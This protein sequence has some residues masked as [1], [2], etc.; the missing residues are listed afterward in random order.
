MTHRSLSM[1]QISLRPI[2]L[3]ACLPLLW[4]LLTPGVRADVFG[5]LRISVRDAAGKPVQSANIIFHD[6]AGV[7]TDF[8]VLSDASGSVLSPPLEN[9]PWRITTQIVTFNTDTR[10]V[11]VAAD[12]T[13]EVA[14]LLTKR[15]VSRTSTVTLGRSP[16][17]DSTRLGQSDIR[18]IPLTG[19]NPQNFSRTLLR[20]PGFVGSSVNVVHPR[21]E[22]GSLSIY[23]D[24]FQL[25]GALQGR[26]GPLISPD[27]I[28]SA[29]IQTG[30]YAPEYGSETAAVVNLSLRSG[31]IKPFGSVSFGAGGYRTLDQE[32][33]FGGQ[34]GAK[35]EQSGP[36]RYLFNIINRS[37]DNSVEAPQPDHQ[38]AHNHG[39]ALTAF[40]NLSY[41][42][43]RNDSFSL[44]L[45]TAP[46]TTQ[47]ANRYGL[48]DKYV[49]VGQGYGYGGARNADGSSAGVAPDPAL[50]GS[51]LTPLKSQQ[52][53]GQDVYQND[54][55]KFSALNYR[56]NFG[57]ALT[58]LLSFGASTSRLD[59]RNRNPSI[60]L[61]SIDP[62]TGLLTTVD[63]SIEYSPTIQRKSAQTEVSGSLTKSAGQHTYKAGLL[64][65]RQ[66][67]SE[68]YNII[69]Q[70]QL[71]LDSEAA[72]Q[73]GGP[74]L[75]PDGTYQ[76]DAAGNPVLDVL[77]NQIYAL[78][79]GATTPTVAVHRSG[80][81]NAAYIQDTWRATRKLTAN[82]GLRYDS[83]YG[84][85][86]L[87]TSS[88]KKNYLSPRLNLAYSLT[89][90]TTLTVDY[91]KLFSQPPLAQGAILGT[92]L[93]PQTTDMYEAGLEHRF[94]PQQSAKFSVYYKN[95]RNEFDTGILIP[96]T[97]IGAYTTLQY[98][99]QG[100]HG[101]ELSYDF[102]PRGLTGLGGYF[103]YTNAIARPNG[104]DQTGAP[105]PLVND[106]DQ[107]NTISTGFSYTF[108][109]Q[110]FAGFDVYYG[111]G[112]AS[113][114]LTPIG[115]SNN[116][117]LGGGQRNSH[118]SVN[119]RLGHPHLLGPAGLELDVENVFNDLSV[120]NF[121]SGYSGTRFQQGRRAVLRVT[122][123]F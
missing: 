12:T 52:D 22:H 4:L 10:T 39:R 81:Y 19:S 73:L 80:Y 123:S 94:T 60:S 63:N 35:P 101:Y 59:I 121:N 50:Y 18:K 15:V 68:L 41:S 99:S 75:A 66:S 113:S 55:N 110:A 65:T 44:L 37:T 105:A 104:V 79:P 2:S 96:Y 13:T 58:G 97:Q 9:R 119:L 28:Q 120:L 69:P 103:A 26:A 38:D 57:G 45:N 67:G 5:R 23:I 62:A 112:E 106:H 61:S 8:N 11:T 86:N 24:G 85:Q 56:H 89:P 111:S 118:T 34:I 90:K 46:A 83:Y 77:G 33:T 16:T 54:E 43:G 98:S 84:K 17:T 115:P 74:N 25:P 30:G 27:I 116:N 87:S 82:Y 51:Q 95:T 6:T 108:A 36:F 107:L 91:D 31:P 42:A 53:A 47:V 122:G 72:V 92:N 71:A 32:L 70:S 114:P 49:P 7:Y 64:L 109:S 48:P 21:G 76:T 40:G 88:V 117:T 78:T 1:R 14:I 20:A 93:V 3:L 29:D 100:T 102:A